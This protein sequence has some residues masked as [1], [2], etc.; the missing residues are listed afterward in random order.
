M[1]NYENISVVIPTLGGRFL[2]KT[3]I[4]LNSGSLLPK[5][6]L[7]CIPKNT[8]FDSSILEINNVKIIKVPYRGQVAQRAFGF[9]R[10]KY[11]YVLQLDDDI[12]VDSLCLERLF[13][14]SQELGLNVAISPAFIDGV[15]KN[16]VYTKPHHNKFLLDI[17]Y[18]LMN[19]IDGYQPGK[20]DKS[21]SAMGINSDEKAVDIIEVDWLPGGCVLH[22]RKSLILED[23][24]KR[25]GKA[26]YEDLMHSFLLKRND[27]RLY[28]DTHAY[29]AIEISNK[30]NINF[31]IF[32][33]DI[34]ND[35][36]ARKYYM[37]KI[38]SLSLRIY[39]FYLFR[40]ASYLYSRAF[41]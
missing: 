34:Y 19:G 24:W 1:P 36:L 28:V 38:E 37:K 10:A 40:F 35:F 22:K 9:Q 6:I 23:Y 7:V 15:T 14:R 11:E 29:C 27:I 39:L 5:E 16:S 20:I 17:Y 26:Y 25:C 21:G 32:I 31:N 13:K 18:F 8:S 12:S 2:K 3:L 4:E 30:S 33:K 41:S